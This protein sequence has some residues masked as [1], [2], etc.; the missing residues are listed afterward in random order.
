MVENIKISTTASERSVPKLPP[1]NNFQ[2]MR[3]YSRKGCQIL[4][5]NTVSHLFLLHLFFL[6][7][8]SCCK[9]VVASKTRSQCN[10]LDVNKL[11]H[12]AWF[13]PRIGHWEPC[14]KIVSQIPTCN[15]SGIPVGK[16]SIW[17]EEAISLRYPPWAHILIDV[18]KL[19]SNKWSKNPS[20][21]KFKNTCTNAIV[22]MLQ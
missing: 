3:V 14:S 2:R 6:S 11:L 21:I 9:A 8:S 19:I 10:S 15:I 16:L 1:C 12:H 18:L 22:K 13:E 17:S 4:R 20:Y 7:V 5:T